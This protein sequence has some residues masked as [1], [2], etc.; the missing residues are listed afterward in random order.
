MA[1]KGWVVL[2][3]M[4]G[5]ALAGCSSQ[6][7]GKV[8]E[9]ETK[10]GAAIVWQAA[11]ARVAE[12]NGR[13]YYL[14]E[15]GFTCASG[16]VPGTAER[17]WREHVSISDGQL[18]DSGTLCNDTVTLVGPVDAALEVSRD[19]AWLRTGGKV[20]RYFPAPPLPRGAGEPHE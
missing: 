15:E 12:L 13:H 4:A 2:G 11:P 19:L 3:W 6:P 10:P 7:A 1:G 5:L 20:Y 18:L 8:S 14:L 16:M 9:P 17:S